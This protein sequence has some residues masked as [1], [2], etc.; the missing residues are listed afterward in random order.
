LENGKLREAIAEYEAAMRINAMQPLAHSALGVAFL[1]AGQPEQ[2]ILHLE[3]ALKIAPNFAEAHYNLGNTYLQTGQAREA[4]EHYRRALELNPEDLEAQNNLAWL[5]ATSPRPEIRDGPKAVELA[6]R[7]DSLTHGAS[8]IVAATLAAAYAESGRFAEA[9]KT[10]QRAA[11]LATAR[12]QTE[13]A[14]IN[15]RQLALYESGSAFRD[16]R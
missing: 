3:A 9:V 1:E 4:I 2:S 10:A 15:L 7:A 16:R 6:E 12:G 14:A 5:L 11:N 8:P 13:R